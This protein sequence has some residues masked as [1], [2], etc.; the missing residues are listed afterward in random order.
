[1]VPNYVCTQSFIN[2]YTGKELVLEEAWIQMRQDWIVW[3]KREW[4]LILSWV[5][6]S[7]LRA[8]SANRTARP[9]SRAYWTLNW[10]CFIC[11]HLCSV[12]GGHV[13]SVGH[14]VF[15]RFN[16]GPRINDGSWRGSCRYTPQ[17]FICGS[18][19]LK[20]HIS[21]WLSRIR[22]KNFFLV[23]VSPNKLQIQTNPG[24]QSQVWIKRR[25][26]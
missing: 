21:S 15:S 23:T 19:T 11:V 4:V 18:K 5:Y 1:M 8:S 10:W 16:T 17:T 14:T 13:R 24:P 9:G 3:K 12:G 22:D 25:G 20:S 7:I 2:Q 6:L 26:R